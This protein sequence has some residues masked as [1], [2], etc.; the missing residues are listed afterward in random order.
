[1]EGYLV[2]LT[3]KTMYTSIFNRFVYV[4]NQPMCAVV[5]P[6]CRVIYPSLALCPASASKPSHTAVPTFGK[7][8]DI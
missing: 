4:T 8:S 7:P 3:M 6:S 1:M 2:H 5:T